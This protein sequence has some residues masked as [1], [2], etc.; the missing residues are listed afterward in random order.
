MQSGRCL[1]GVTS[2]FRASESDVRQFS[3]V[4]WRC[5]FV[6]FWGVFWWWFTV[7]Q[8]A[9]LDAFAWFWGLFWWWCAVADAAAWDASGGISPGRCLGGVTSSLRASE[10]DVRHFSWV[11]WRCV[12]VWLWGVFWWWFTVAQAAA[13]DAFAWCWS[14]FRGWFAVAEAATLD[15]DASGPIFSRCSLVVA[16]AV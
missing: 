1:G 5:V 10:S 11:V 9:A 6:W 14:L 12:F 8:A 4:V 3:W 16:L 13:L 15:A 7:A 2:S